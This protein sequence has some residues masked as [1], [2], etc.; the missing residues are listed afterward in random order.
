MVEISKI[1]GQ[2]LAAIARPEDHPDANL[3]GAF[4]ER[5]LGNRERAQVLEHLSRCM[6]CR[7]VV[8]LSSMPSE[9]AQIVSVAS[10]PGWLSW[11]ILRW[12]VV[13]CV[14]TVGAVVAIHKK[15]ENLNGAPTIAET[16]PAVEM[17]A[18]TQTVA[19]PNGGKDA[20]VSSS[21]V[22][23]A[24][25]GVG[26][27]LAKAVPGRA[28][29][30]V[31]ESRDAQVDAAAASKGPI[32]V[33]LTPRW[34]LSSDGTLQRSLD[35]GSTWQTITVSN[36]KASFRALAANGLDIWVGGSA[37]ALFHSSDAGEHWT[38]VRPVVN[39]QV[40][41]ADIIG[42]EFPDLLHGKLTIADPAA[43]ALNRSWQPGQSLPQYDF[44]ADS[45]G[46]DV[47]A[48]KIPVPALPGKQ[49]WTTADAGQT[50]EKK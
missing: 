38:R 28:K 25:A 30:A 2:R 9:R 21:P 7:E 29:D 22:E 39:G 27:P 40:L 15:N 10:G 26:S 17:Q 1:V 33:N 11:P 36:S 47:V 16:R 13:A 34:T 49:T 35:S 4:A 32:P 23:M 12:G 43:Q 24:D 41:R 19:S 3:L 20:A 44:P 31:A 46:Q 37:G 18:P 48:Q 14:V 45:R 5:A 6:S 50:W 8:S 42:V